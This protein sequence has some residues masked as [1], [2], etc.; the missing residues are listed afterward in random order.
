MIWK[1]RKENTQMQDCLK[2]KFVIYCTLLR[3]CLLCFG[4]F[5]DPELYEK[6]RQEYLQEREEFRQT[7]TRKKMKRLH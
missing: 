4:R 1:C 5:N 3:D 6:C 2:A 7:G